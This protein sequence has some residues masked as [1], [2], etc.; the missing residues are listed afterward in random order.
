MSAELIIP[1]LIIM[2]CWGFSALFSG[3]EIGIISLDLFQ[4]ATRSRK[5]SRRAR[6]LMQMMKNP[7][8][9]LTALLIGNNIAN[10]TG[11]VLAASI[12]RNY[13]GNYGPLVS[14]VIMTVWLLIAGEIIPKFFFYQ[15]AIPASI[16]LVP[17][18]RMV[19]FLFF[20]IAFVNR[21]L[22]ESILSLIQ[23]KKRKH[24]TFVTKEE[25]KLMMSPYEQFVRMP[26]Y[27]KELIYRALQ[28]SETKVKDIMIPLLDVVSIADTASINLAIQKIVT[29]GHSRLPVYSS[30][31][32]QLTGI[33]Y[34]K[35]IM[36]NKNN[37]RQISGLVRTPK[38]VSKYQKVEELLKELKQ[39]Q[40]ELAFTLDEYGDIAG[41]V[42]LEDGIEELV[43]EIED[44]HDD[45]KKPL[46]QKARDGSRIIT[47]NMSLN[48]FNQ[49]FKTK[50]PPGPYKTVAGFILTL[51][52]HIP[53]QG[54]TV[55][56]RKW[57]FRILEASPQRINR[58]NVSRIK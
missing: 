53:K 41:I 40:C 35:D 6:I 8:Y 20:P 1:G 22:S 10:V 55:K 31:L 3:S 32:R 28:Y 45:L 25:L 46:I 52:Q 57:K 23:G 24:T 13:M 16:H 47:G 21:K 9:L 33:V 58:I 29:S 2:L 42:T 26:L 38:F 11:S 54:D 37:A 34:A 51:T 17:F 19:R 39:D 50:F 49:Y 44:E 48:S 27:E 18:F 12:A 43:G 7:E 15:H 56:Y 36:K 14:T 30:K 4:L 5:G